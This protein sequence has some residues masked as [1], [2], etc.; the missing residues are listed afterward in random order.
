MGIFNFFIV[1]P[2]MLAA[3]V[4]GGLVHTI[5]GD[6]PALG[7]VLGGA[8]LVIGGLCTL[9]VAEPQPGE[10]VCLSGVGAEKA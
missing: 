1:I 3:S 9:R 2:Q 10:A 4:L 8:S 5:F 6:R 7:L